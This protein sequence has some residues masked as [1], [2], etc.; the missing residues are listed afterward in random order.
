MGVTSMPIAKNAN[1]AA[2]VD[3][4]HANGNVHGANVTSN[5]IVAQAVVDIT[6]A[7]TNEAAT[8][9]ATGAVHATTAAGMVDNQQLPA[10][11]GSAAGPSTSHPP[12][13]AAADALP[14]VQIESGAAVAAAPATSP[15]LLG[16]KRTHSAAV[17]D[18]DV[19]Q[20]DDEDNTETNSAM[21]QEDGSA[22]DT[23]G[24]NDA[25]A[26]GVAGPSTTAQVTAGQPPLPQ[27]LSDAVKANLEK[28]RER[29]TDLLK[30]AVSGAT[31]LVATVCSD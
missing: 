9:D 10:A 31:Q 4:V 7:V 27:G 30:A 17:K 22:A 20:L 28:Y 25:A 6:A 16:Q 15:A 26:A 19:D 11:V 12:T 14:A 29:V 18:E 2:R 5:G 24:A 1:F 3:D 8:G 21:D 23:A 13:A